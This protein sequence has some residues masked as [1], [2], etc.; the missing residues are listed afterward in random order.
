MK[1]ATRLGVSLLAVLTLAP[2]HLTA[3]ATLASQAV[4]KTKEGAEKTKDAVVKGT[5]ACAAWS[6]G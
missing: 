1:S 2:A 3:K 4:E 5:K 6:I